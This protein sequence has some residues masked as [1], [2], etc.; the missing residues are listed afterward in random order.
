MSF[1]KA[2]LINLG[3][4][5][6]QGFPTRLAWRRSS[7][8]DGGACVEVAMSGHRVMVRQSVTPGLTLN[9]SRDQW[10]AFLAAIQAGDFR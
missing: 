4:R 6:D 7:T 3:G 5:V 10:R 9:F 1:R 8:C 2:S